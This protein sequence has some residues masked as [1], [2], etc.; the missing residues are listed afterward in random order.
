MWCV[1]D[2]TLNLPILRHVRV[3]RHTGPAE[4]G[5]PKSKDCTPRQLPCR[6]VNTVEPTAMGEYNVYLYNG[7]NRELHSL[8]GVFV[9]L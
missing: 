5:N 1:I 4:S 8:G 7:K 6:V 9:C 3:D 2:N